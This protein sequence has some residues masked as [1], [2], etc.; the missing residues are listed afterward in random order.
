M[1]NKK[2]NPDGSVTVDPEVIIK[3]AHKV[4]S[5]WYLVL[6]VVALIIILVVSSPDPYAS[7]LVFMLDGVGVT[8]LVTLISFFLV[9]IV[10]LLGGLGRISTN[11][12]LRGIAT[13][14]VEVIRG[15]PLLVQLIF[16]YFAMPAVIRQLGTALN[17][18]SMATYKTEPLAMAIVGLT[19]CYGAYMSEVYRAGIQSIPRGQMEAARSLG[20][21]YVQAMRYVVLP[22]AFRV[23]L[24]PLGNEFITLLK[25]SSLVSVVSVADL[26][27][28]GREYTAT[29]F[30]PIETYSML[31][32][33]YL[34]MT[35]LTARLVNY[36]EKITK[37][38]R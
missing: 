37:L 23:I 19:I 29:H 18:Q 10:G 33:V 24:P 14:Y 12:I 6:G 36:T 35:L 30:N 9:L 8:I 15:I 13:V 20:M 7:M 2:L 22:Q 1:D 34:V 17:N 4:E 32:L 27:R 3:T 25:D 21:T 28:R 5:G 11:P 31:A 26:T 38:E 16:W